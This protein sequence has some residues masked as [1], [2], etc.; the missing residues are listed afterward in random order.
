MVIVS[1]SMN[2]QPIIYVMKTQIVL[3]H[4]VFFLADAIPDLW[5]MER[6]VLK[7]LALKTSVIQTRVVF[8]QLLTS[9]FVRRDSIVINPAHV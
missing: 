7:V 2:V 3:T 8:L 1:I 4:P 6:I 5:A 9:V